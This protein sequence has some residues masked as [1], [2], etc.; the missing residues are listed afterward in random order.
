MPKTPGRKRRFF[1]KPWAA[2]ARRAHL[3]ELERQ[4]KAEAEARSNVRVSPPHDDPDVDPIFAELVDRDAS[5]RAAR[6]VVLPG[7]EP[8][9]P[10]IPAPPGVPSTLDTPTAATPVQDRPW[11]SEPID[12]PIDPDEAVAEGLLLAEN[13]VIM[14]MKNR[15]I[16]QTLAPDGF[17]TTDHINEARLELI[18]ASDELRRS[19]EI[20]QREYVGALQRPGKAPTPHSYRRR[21]AGNLRLRE[22]V[23]RRT[24]EILRDLGDNSAYLAS[25]VDR[26]RRDA[27]REIGDALL[28]RLDRRLAG[29]AAEP[30][31]QDAVDAAEREARIGAVHGD[32]NALADGRSRERDPSAETT[33]IAARRIAEAQD[34]YG[35]F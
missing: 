9:T 35:A 3:A 12:N 15:M 22:Q 26:A 18:E 31:A 21:D 25:I 33:G 2:A 6:P 27:W 5:E 19:A 34:P 4:A 1:F 10:P 14:G 7:L 30:T 23:G 16:M 17:A 13:A 24:A 28:D 11:I 32:L 8:P 20:A 29:G